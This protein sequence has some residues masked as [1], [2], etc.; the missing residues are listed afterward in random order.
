[1]SDSELP[2][3]RAAHFRS[4]A[5][6]LR[7]LAGELPY[8]PNRRAQLLALAD[9][10]D[11]YA[12]RWEPVPAGPPSDDLAEAA[13]QVREG[14]ERISRQLALIRRLDAAGRR[15]DARAARELL[16]AITDTVN[17]ARRH[18]TAKRRHPR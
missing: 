13:R 12:D 7:A 9:G 14:E 15:E 8:D 2:Q 11:R 16:G 5:D 17:V 1:M 4:V 6:R 3:S 18:L 10:F